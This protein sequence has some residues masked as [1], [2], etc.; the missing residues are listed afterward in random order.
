MS[1]QLTVILCQDTQI[2]AMK[3]LL[4]FP[5]CSLGGWVNSRS[6]PLMA[7]RVGWVWRSWETALDVRSTLSPTTSAP[8][9]LVPFALFP[10][11]PFPSFPFASGAADIRSLGHQFRS[12]AFDPWGTTTRSVP[13]PNFPLLAHLLHQPQSG[14]LDGIPTNRASY[15][16]L[17]GPTDRCGSTWQAVSLPRS[18]I[19][20]ER[21]IQ[22]CI[23]PPPLSFYP[24]RVMAHSFDA[25]F[26]R[27]SRQSRPRIPL[28]AFRIYPSSLGAI[29]LRSAQIYGRTVSR[30]IPAGAWTLCYPV[31]IDLL[32]AFLLTDELAR[33]VPGIRRSSIPPIQ[34][35]SPH[36]NALSVY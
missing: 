31:T 19:P 33:F 23:R 12:A 25:P 30:H 6:P 34:L 2:L 35:A 29:P 32:A 7:L 18:S 16:A 27:T 22:K 15:S 36:R 3:F 8:P 28:G 20:I 24:L 21:P 11:K 13:Q 17:N 4:Y 26:I 9:S 1:Y 14:C 10:S 5:S